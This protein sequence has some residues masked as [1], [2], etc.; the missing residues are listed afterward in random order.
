[1]TAS[2]ESCDFAAKVAVFRRLRKSLFRGLLAGA[3]PGA[4]FIALELG[5]AAHADYWILRNFK[6]GGKARS[7]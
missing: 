4:L 6:S 1:M 7:G 3:H 2:R 5:A